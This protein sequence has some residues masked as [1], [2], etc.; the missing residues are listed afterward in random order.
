MACGALIQDG[1]VERGE[2]LTMEEHESEQGNED[3]TWPGGIWHCQCSRVLIEEGMCSPR[4]CQTLILRRVR[5]LQCFRRGDMTHP[6]CYEA[7]S[8]GKDEFGPLYSFP[9]ALEPTLECGL[10]D[11]EVSKAEP[12]KLADQKWFVEEWEVYVGV[13]LPGDGE[14][15]GL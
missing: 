5:P 10:A 9:L 3:A 2:R 14:V 1:W 13:L 15:D 11:G 12:T 8:S 4:R 7:T 6:V